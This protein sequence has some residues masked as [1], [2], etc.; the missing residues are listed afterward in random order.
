M[1][2]IDYLSYI[3][4]AVKHQN[5]QISLFECTS[6]SLSRCQAQL[7]VKMSI[8]N[9][10]DKALVTFQAASECCKVVIWMMAYEC[11]D[12]Y[13]KYDTLKIIG[14]DVK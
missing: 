10:A 7:D 12:I 1:S 13:F 9:E 6:E 14:T 11:R 5:T 8:V 4:T 3:A 2:E